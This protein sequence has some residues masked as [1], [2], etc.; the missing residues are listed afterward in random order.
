MGQIEQ[1]LY[2]I[3]VWKQCHGIRYR[4]FQAPSLAG[5]AG[6][7]PRASRTGHQLGA[8]EPKCHRA[9][10]GGANNVPGNLPGIPEAREI[11][12]GIPLE[13]ATS[14]G[15]PPVILPWEFPV[16][17]DARPIC[18]GIPHGIS[19]GIRDRQPYSPVSP[20]ILSRRQ[21]LQ[22]SGGNREN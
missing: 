20:P 3:M 17:S 13:V 1:S 15:G 11:S 7:G 19:R 5:N 18:R 16:I 4:G 2:A 10:R 8:T 9:I 14:Q 12:R 22:T 21:N 6:T